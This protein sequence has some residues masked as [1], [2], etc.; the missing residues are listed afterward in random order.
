MDK[1][2][3]IGRIYKILPMKESLDKSEISKEDF[4]SY[5]VKQCIDFS[6]MDIDDKVKEKIL[7]TLRGVKNLYVELS[8]KDVKSSILRLTNLIDREV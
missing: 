2:L 7:T 4:E 6:G 5:I 8:V 3:I 1:S